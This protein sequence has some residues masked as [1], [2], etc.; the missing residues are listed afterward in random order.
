MIPPYLEDPC[1]WYGCI[2]ARVCIS[3]RR[4][5]ARAKRSARNARDARGNRAER[6]RFG[7]RASAVVGTV[8]IDVVT[9]A[10]VLER[11]LDECADVGVGETVVHVL[12]IATPR[13]DALRAKE[14]QLLRHGRE[15]DARSV[16]QL[17]HAPLAFA[18][19][20]EET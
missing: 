18:E 14:P 9:F 10:R 17:G 8:V 7:E 11:A 2:T 19:P 6:G 20:I 1:R 12:P 13:D 4:A 15:S 3:A 16:G 5:F